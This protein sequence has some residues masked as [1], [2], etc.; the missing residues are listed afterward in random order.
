MTMVQGL[1]IS[2][3]CFLYPLIP[4]THNFRRTSRYFSANCACKQTPDHNNTRFL[5]GRKSERSSVV[6]LHLAKV[7][8]ESSNL[9][10]RSILKPNWV[11][12]SGFFYSTHSEIASVTCGA[13]RLGGLR[14]CAPSARS[15]HFK[16]QLG[17]QFGLFF[18]HD[19]SA[20][21][22]FSCGLGCGSL[23]SKGRV[24]C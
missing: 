14:C 23:Q 17:N 13:A 15:L 21:R 10:A 1:D 4:T 2:S 7:V 16:A 24:S 20:G 3:P 5:S 9:F 6:E 22:R 19:P 18:V 8:V 12:S 11:T